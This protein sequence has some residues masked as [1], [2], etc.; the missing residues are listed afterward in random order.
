MA[1]SP[2]RNRNRAADRKPHANDEQGAVSAVFRM[3]PARIREAALKTAWGLLSGMLGGFLLAQIPDTPGL[4]L[5]IAVIGGLGIIGALV[6][7]VMSVREL[8]SR[9]CIDRTGIAWLPAWAGFRMT[10]DDIESW[11]MTDE[12]GLPTNVQQLKLFRYD[13]KFPT[14]VDTS[15]MS[16]GSRS[17][18]RRVLCEVAR[19]KNGG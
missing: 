1:A 8:T 12:L 5:N 2:R 9:L 16:I 7:F 18:L 14:L 15:W 17:T 19:E 3:R 10:W 6:F 4:A 13:S 11:E